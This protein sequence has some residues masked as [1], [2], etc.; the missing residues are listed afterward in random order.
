MKNV[1]LKSTVYILIGMS[2]FIWFGLA[3]ASDLNLSLAKDFFSLVPKVVSLDLL[4]IAVFVKWGWKFKFFRG[5]LVPFPDLNGTWIGH[6]YSNWIDDETG[7]KLAP[8]PVMLTVKQSFFST[9]YVI[10]SAEMQSDS[11]IEG[12]LIDEQRQQKQ[13]S[14]SYKSSP[15]LSIAHR[16]P[17]HDGAC[18]LSIIEKPKRKLSGR[19]WTERKTTG[20]MIFTYHSE[21][22]LDEL[23]EEH[24]DHPKTEPENRR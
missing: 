17:P 12:F 19:Y 3:W 2:G 20:E 5:W 11:Y 7:D 9:S 8:I 4:I 22:L 21:E 14:Y 10:R 15:R 18:V 16:S 1:V 24:S 23:P 6:V 13:L